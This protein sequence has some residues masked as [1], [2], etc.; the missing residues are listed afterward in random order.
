[1]D[2]IQELKKLPQ[3]IQDILLSPFGAQVNSTIIAKYNLKKDLADKMLDLV[4][5]I[6]LK[7]LDIMNLPGKL[8]SVLGLP[9]DRAQALALDLVGL[10]LL[11]ADDYFQGAV[12]KF[13]AANG[14]G[15]D[16]YQ[17]KTAEIRTALEK[18]REIYKDQSE[19]KEYVPKFLDLEERNK[20]ESDNQE[21]IDALSL[22]N[23]D[24]INILN[25]KDDNEII[26]DYNET[27]IGL[28]EADERFKRDLETT[29]YNNQELISDIKINTNGNEAKPTVANWLK[30]FIMENGSDLFG[31]VTLVKYLTDNH[32]V[33][34]IPEAERNLIKKLLKLYRNL[35]FFPSS[36]ENIPLEEW[37]IFPVDQAALEARGVKPRAKINDILDEATP[38][39]PV[40]NNPKLKAESQNEASKIAPELVAVVSPAKAIPASSD[41]KP[42]AVPAPSE[43][44]QLQD[45]LVKYPAGSFEYKTIQQEIKRLKRLSQKQD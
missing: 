35:V 43:L 1:M 18:E 10:K 11:V 14:G 21:K 38:F 45:L 33:K 23:E 12:S 40:V 19:E 27:L 2:Y 20:P 3:A 8:I 13:L 16:A 32:N 42:A 31:N 17:I 37:E 34:R 36:M 44:E 30:D 26:L 6:Y 9:P 29:L 7:K 15:L 4:N 5:D 24:L 25:F 41:L 28:I 39:S 22:F